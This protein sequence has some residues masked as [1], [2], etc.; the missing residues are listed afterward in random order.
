MFWAFVKNL[1]LLYS[2]IRSFKNKLGINLV[3]YKQIVKVL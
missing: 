3:V 2:E 1:L